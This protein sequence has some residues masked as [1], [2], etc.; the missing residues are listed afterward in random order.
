[1]QLQETVG[2]LSF[3]AGVCDPPRFT[4]SSRIMMRLAAQRSTRASRS[5]R[6][7]RVQPQPAQNLP[8]PLYSVV[9]PQLPPARVLEEEA[10]QS[11][12]HNFSAGPAQLPLSVLSR[13]RDEL[14]SWPDAPG[15]SP[16]CISH[17]EAGGAYQKL[18]TRLA[19]QIR[20]TLDVPDNY[21]V[22]FMQGG[23]HAQFAAA[24]LNLC[25]RPAA[26]A[27]ASG[28][29]AFES[30]PV[31]AVD[32]GFW[33]R[34][35]AAEIGRYAPVRWVA[36]ADP[37][38]AAAT[39]GDACVSEAERDWRHGD[40]MHT[41]LPPVDS[42]VVDDDAAF[43]HLCANETINGLELIEDP[44]LPSGAPPLVADFTS[45]LLSRPMDVSKYGVVYCSGGKNLGPAGGTLV[46]VRDDL[47]GGGREHPLCP[48]V[49]SYSKFAT[50][51]P[52]PNLY[53]T[54]PTYAIYMMSLVLDDLTARGGLEWAAQ[55]TEQLSA[56]LYEAIDGSDGFYS[57]RVEAGSRSRV[58]VPFSVVGSCGRSPS[59]SAA[60]EKLFVEQAEASGFRHIAGHPLHGGIRASIYNGVPDSAVNALLGFMDDFRLQH[61]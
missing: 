45:T 48:S 43:V 59:E 32:T 26:E 25:G 54:P 11:Q 18:A 13:A 55:R 24:P 10:V 3:W 34:R 17:R 57:N 46:L 61:A 36:S 42:W 31:A 23:A 50:T 35:A 16:M 39:F 40:C 56:R 41:R 51:W 7:L 53:A 38:E 33:A 12:V 52:I 15:Q 37:D 60:L 1:M 21:Q 27:R 29:H 5:V 2:T 14:L 30:R 49:L 20:A 28:H 4:T 19:L 58:S 8:E 44:S 47:I 6:R 9:P 22:L